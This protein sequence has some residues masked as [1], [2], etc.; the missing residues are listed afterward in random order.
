MVAEEELLLADGE[1]P[2]IDD[3]VV[4]WNIW[5]AGDSVDLDL[6]DSASSS[7]SYAHEQTPRRKPVAT[8]DHPTARD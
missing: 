6:L 8:T 7:R 1:T 3:L 2:P 4:R 5:P